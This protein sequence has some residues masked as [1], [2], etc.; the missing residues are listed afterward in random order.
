MSHKPHPPVKVAI[1]HKSPVPLHAQ[2][3]QLFRKM[4]EAHQD[5][6]EP[7][8]SNE[9]DLARQLGTSR[10][11]VRQA[12]NK[13]VIEGL[14]VRK[15]G[16]GTFLAD[17]S[18]NTRIHN[19]L[20]FS[21]E[22]AAKGIRIRNFALETRWEEADGETATFFH[23]PKGKKILRLERLRGNESHPFVWFISWFHPRTGLTGNEDFSR[24]LYDIL[25]KD[26]SVIVK[27]SKEEISAGLADKEL[28]RMLQIKPGDP[29]LKRKRYVFDPGGRPVEYNLGFYRADSFIYTIESEREI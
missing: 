13:L 29:I 21:Q 3:E 19:W 4:I 7:L 20:S 6:G 24:P 8:F 5:H 28:A 10:N 23:I 1:D 15:K 9:A 2:V 26:H 27:L 16:V 17:R 11:T 14:L 12:L 25:E 22:M 18:V